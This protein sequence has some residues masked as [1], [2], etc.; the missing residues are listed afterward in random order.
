MKVTKTNESIEK[1]EPN[2]DE[3]Y[4]N[5]LRGVAGDHISERKGNF[6]KLQNEK[7][8]K[9]GDSHI[10]L[11]RDRPSS[12][13]S[14]YGGRG[15]AKANSIDIVVGRLS[16]VPVESNLNN[17][18]LWVNPDFKN[19]AARIY[20]SQKTDVDK[21][22]DTQFGKSGISSAK[23]AVAIKAD[24]VRLI[25]RSS[26]KLVTHADTTDSRGL[27]NLEKVG[28]DLIAGIPYDP[29]NPERN[30]KLGLAQ[31]KDDMQP[32]PKGNNLKEAFK[33][34]ANQL[35]Q[36][37][38]VLSTFVNMQMEFNNYVTMHT[39]IENFYGLPGYPSKDLP[40]PNIEMNF[41]VFEKTI[42]DIMKFKMQY[43]NYFNETYL[44]TASPKYINSRYHHLN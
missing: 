41:D 24:D 23:S 4:Y 15:E 31:Y 28:V 35:D 44:S 18:P 38:G 30:R 6:Y 39:H 42:G 40:G 8:I 22:F 14:G 26:V 13:L 17:E 34:L 10:V 20:I 21:N 33:D 9:Q 29:L 11:G 5:N 25:S 27:Q 19:D 3:S 32:I 12:P 16:C 36:L 1:I 2:I 37:A 7:H 43:L